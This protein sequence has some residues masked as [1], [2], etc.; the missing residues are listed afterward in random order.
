MATIGNDISQAKKLL[1]EGELVAI[2]TE[3][4]Y[5]LA[6][7]ALNPEAV[8]QIFVVKERP[9][10]DP[11][12]VHVASIDQAQQFITAVPEKAIQLARHFWPGPLTLVLPKQSIIPDIVTS[13]LSTVGIR[14]P[15]HDL[16]RQ[17]LSELP[18]PLAAPS[19]NPFGYVSPTTAEHVNNQ[20]G[21]KIKYILDGGPCRIGLE[22]T[23]VGFENDQA[24]IYRRGGVSEEEISKVIGE[25]S[26][27]L[28]SSNPVAPGQ[29]DSH[30]APNK[31]FYLGD[32][33]ELKKE[34]TGKKVGV[35]RFMGNSDSS[36]NYK[37]ILSQSGNLEE[38][39]RNLFA[40]LRQFDQMEIEVILAEPVPDSG[41]GKA[42]ND[43]LRRA[44]TK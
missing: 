16:T 24:V 4:V 21:H 23:I 22:S 7:N 43:R 13:G 2:P 26:Y 5:G 40:A 30:Y 44:A 8:T 10:F 42:I 18:F 17:L 20:L 14:C 33:N 35:L 32:I 25:V 6:A 29:L 34:F 12:I 3:T 27:R 11:L 31:K 37:L 19:A 15:D 41:I 38:A 1:Q 28:A 36:D 9:S 39:A